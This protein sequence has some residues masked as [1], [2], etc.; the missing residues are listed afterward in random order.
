MTK[1]WADRGASYMAKRLL[2]SAEP[3]SPAPLPK[4]CPTVQRHPN[5]TRA[6]LL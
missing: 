2:V 4:R 5:P 1:L 3:G 6:D